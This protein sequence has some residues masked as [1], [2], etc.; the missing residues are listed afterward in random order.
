MKNLYDYFYK[1]LTSNGT[2]GYPAIDHKI[3]AELRE[4]KISFYIHADGRDSDTM[5]FYVEKDGTL[6]LKTHAASSESTVG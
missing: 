6:T 3:R 2:V 4:G 1:N 5:D